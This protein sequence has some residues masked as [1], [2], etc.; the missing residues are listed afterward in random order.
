M[1]K[2]MNQTC[3]VHLTCRSNTTMSHCVCTLYFCWIYSRHCYV[4]VQCCFE[5]ML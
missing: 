5:E 2:C 4:Y 1:Y 3:F